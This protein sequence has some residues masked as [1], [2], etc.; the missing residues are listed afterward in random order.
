MT[1]RPTLAA[2]VEDL[3]LGVL[4]VVTAPRGLDVAVG[5]VLIH[6]PL[7]KA[8]AQ[9]G[10][11]ILAV[12]I[13]ASRRDAVDLVE[14]C[15]GDGA[16]A[17]VIKA[18]DV[19][20]DPIVRAAE[21]GGV[22]LLAA[23]AEI[24]WGQLHG[25]LRTA[26]AVARPSEHGE[27]PVGDLFA[28]ANAVATLV[29]GPATIE[30]PH[31]TVLAYS[32]TD[33]PIDEPRRQ[34][35]LG[36]RVPETWLRRLQQAGVFRRLW[37]TDDVVRWE[38]D[39]GDTDDLAPRL[40]IAVRAGEEIL[41][42]IWVAEGRKPL[43]ADAEAALREAA[44]IAALHLL[45]HRANEDLER[46]Q[47]AELLRQ[48]LD[49]RLPAEVA[50]PSLGLPVEG[51]CTVV[52]FLLD[53]A[54]EAEAAVKA[55]RTVDLVALYCEAFRRKAVSTV[56][57][58]TIYV[59]LPEQ[60]D[61]Q[62][63]RL[64]ALARDVIERAGESLRVELRVG[65]GST[66]ASLSDAPR[67]RKEADRV[68]QVLRTRPG[69][70][71]ATIDEV[72]GLAVLLELR[73]LARERPELRVGRLHHLVEQDERRGTEYIPTLRSY[74]AHFGD[75]P[76]AAAD[77]GVHPNTFRYRL[78]RLTEVSGIDFDDPDERLVAE[79]QLRFLDD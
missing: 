56:V 30:D 3:A 27:V 59:L 1:D 71:I 48:A 2:L 79:L 21:E 22:A 78:R 57:G 14:Q 35:I 74:L 11:V 61:V 18:G 60:G 40:A 50:G 55:E 5:D 47:R 72:R 45:R 75:I 39:D 32:S 17:V 23:P 43:D 63:D 33:D 41:G 42:S 37:S 44:G 51:S 62:R 73:D 34:T 16:A 15:G 28:L 58:S 31:S 70:A 53:A 46:R 49:G 10:D 67:S 76:T 19:V 38:G 4:R 8:G 9:S 7:E 6:D 12:G 24:A 65:I 20:P 29:G 54:G 66:V 68:L 26:V 64:V 77:L 25:L 13:D 36:R 52:A 69:E